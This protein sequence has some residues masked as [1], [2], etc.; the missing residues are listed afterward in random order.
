MISR[1]GREKQIIKM[2]TAGLVQLEPVAGK[3]AGDGKAAS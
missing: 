1:E 3:E 2:A